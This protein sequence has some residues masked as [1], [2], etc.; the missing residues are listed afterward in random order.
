MSQV[1][2]DSGFKI[3][4][5]LETGWKRL[6]GH[7]FCGQVRVAIFEVFCVVQSVRPE[8]SEGDAEKP[9]DGGECETTGCVP[10][11]AVCGIGWA[12]G[13][14]VRDRGLRC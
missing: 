5:V 13:V 12:V 1:V 11:E 2:F 14:Q 7:I 8:G 6:A 4:K 9:E 10:G 3:P